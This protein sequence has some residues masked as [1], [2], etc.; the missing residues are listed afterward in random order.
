MSKGTR[1]RK[2]HSRPVDSH[3]IAVPNN[4]RSVIEKRVN[5]EFLRPMQ[6]RRFNSKAQLVAKILDG[7][8]KEDWEG[9]KE[10]A[11]VE[12]DATTLNA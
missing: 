2:R 9:L 7:F 8:F 12:A 4:L 6:V 3:S 1:T 10:L 11:H 5:G